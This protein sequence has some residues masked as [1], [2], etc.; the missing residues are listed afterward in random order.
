MILLDLVVGAVAKLVLYNSHLLAQIEFLLR[1]VEV[2]A[3]L[4]VNAELKFKQ[5]RLASDKRDE[6]LDPL[7]GLKALEY[8]LLV[9]IFYK[10][11]GSDKVREERGALYGF[12]GVYNVIA[13]RWEK[14]HKCLGLCEHNVHICLASE[15]VLVRHGDHLGDALCEDV[16]RK[17]S[18]FGYSRSGK[19]LCDDAHIAFGS[20]YRLLY[21]CDRARE[22]ELFGGDVLRFIKEVSRGAEKHH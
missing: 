12:C 3:N 10:Y 5:L 11:V 15:R 4:F 9:L 21:L 19:T 17:A 18:E 6:K 16:V 20:F 1:S 2:L 13:D 14:L 8:L 7:C 22:E